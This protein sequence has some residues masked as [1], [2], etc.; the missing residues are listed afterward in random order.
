MYKRTRA[1]FITITCTNRISPVSV[2]QHSPILKGKIHTILMITTKDLA[3][4]CHVSRGTVDRALNDKPGISDKT[5]QMIREKAAELG[6]IPHLVGSSLARGKTDSI[7]IIVFDLRNEHF[8]ELV[9]NIESVF[10]KQNIV[11]YV[12]LSEKD[13]EKEKKLLMAM[14]SRRV[15]GILVTSINQGHEF[16]EFLK[17]LSVPVVCISNKVEGIPYVGGR[18]SQAVHNAME[19]VRSRGIRRVYYVCPPMRLEHEQNIGAQKERA[20]AYLSF[21]AD[22]PELTGELI[23]DHDYWEQVKKRISKDEPHAAFLCSSDHYAVKIYHNARLEGYHL[24][25]DFS[26][27]GFDGTKILDYLPQRIDTIKYP[28]DLI[29]LKASEMLM[30]IINGE[31]VN[32][33]LIDCPVLPGS[34]IT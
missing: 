21:M 8:V 28:A 33:C 10:S 34:T 31:D 27:M 29:G 6:Y 4:I 9:H 25:D 19:N 7:G 32:D 3:N 2:I 13:P 20:E 16:T 14:A 1:R 15:D 22:H 5:A 17:K 30:H 26:L 18:N 12:C 11:A 24:P 23:I